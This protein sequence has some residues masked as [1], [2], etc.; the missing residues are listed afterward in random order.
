M[1]WI[2]R[3]SIAF[4]G[5][6]W[7]H[8]AFIVTVLQEVC[9]NKIWGAA[10]FKKNDSEDFSFNEEF[11]MSRLSLY[12]DTDVMFPVKLQSSVK[13]R[14]KTP[15]Q[16]ILKK[17]KKNP[18]ILF[19]NKDI[20]GRNERLHESSAVKDETLRLHCQKKFSKSYKDV[21]SSVSATR[22]K[23]ENIQDESETF[24]WTNFSTKS[25]LWKHFCFC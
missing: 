6:W 12:Q 2:R 15:K 10:W 14:P 5:C 22:L 17:K 21:Q 1:C 3:V 16:N 4:A 19:F 8:L 25:L 7:V 23:K 11:K 13:K 18:N 24:K 9:Q 20:S